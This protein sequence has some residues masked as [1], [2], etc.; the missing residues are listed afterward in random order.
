MSSMKPNNNQPSGNTPPS[1]QQPQA[2]PQRRG[3][4]VRFPTV[5]PI[6][7]YGLLAVLTI[8]FFYAE[9]LGG[10]L[11]GARDQFEFDWI[12]I[13]ERIYDGEYYRLFT[14]MFLHA[15]LLHWGFNSLA[16]YIF[17]RD[18]ERLFGHVRFALIYVLGGLAGSVGS[19]IYTTAPS[20]GASGAIFAIISAMGVYI[21]IHRHIYGEFAYLRL[22]QLLILG[23]LN[24]VLGFLPGSRID[25]AA[26]LG[27]LLGGFILAWFIC[28]EYEPRR[29]VDQRIVM[30]DTN[31]TEKWLITPILFAIGIVVSVLYAATVA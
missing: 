3:V 5:E 26:H 6:L 16:L 12:K 2:P 19:L 30:V 15:N 23:G 7:T 27:G 22:R 11:G 13:N 10:A 21:Y 29:T 17:G 4:P 9:S 14:S 28:P 24:L 18:V 20:L 1:A 31:T 8:I 25:N